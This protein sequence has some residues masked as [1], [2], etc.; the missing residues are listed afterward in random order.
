MKF[1]PNQRC[2]LTSLR[3]ETQYLFRKLKPQQPFVFLVSLLGAVITG[4][5]DTKSFFTETTNPMILWFPFLKNS[6][7]AAWIAIGTI[8]L[9]YALTWWIDFLAN[10]REATELSQVTKTYLLGMQQGKLKK[11]HTH[12]S[13]NFS[14][15]KDARLSV[16]I[17]VRQGF[18][19]WH[20]QMVCATANVPQR[21]SDALFQLNEGVIGYTF[22]KSRKHAVEFLNLSNHR[23]IPKTYVHLDTD[24]K[25]LISR[26]VKGVLVAASFQD[27]SVASLLAI[28][29]ENDSDLQ[30][31]ESADLHMEVLDWIK[32]QNDLVKLLWR[33]RNNV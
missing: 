9:L 11:F 25:A 26:G 21:E 19:K 10:T 30:A 15:S 16:F 24:N 12:L 2:A 17:P 4:L 14:L 22:L 6:D 5:S 7:A 18:M 28:D 27:Q 1:S 29:T 13:K 3:Y 20:L 8:L 31:M 32:A 23:K 33:M